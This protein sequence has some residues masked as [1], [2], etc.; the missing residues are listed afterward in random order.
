VSHAIFTRWLIRAGSFLHIIITEQ[1]LLSIVLI[2]TFLRKVMDILLPK[3]N[4]GLKMFT[5]IFSRAGKE[6][7]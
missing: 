4:M 2:V 3:Q 6:A 1:E 5:D 7:S